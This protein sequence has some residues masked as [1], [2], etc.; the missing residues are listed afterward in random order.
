MCGSLGVFP[1]LRRQILNY[2]TTILQGKELEHFGLVLYHQHPTLNPEINL[3][4]IPG[5]AEND[6]GV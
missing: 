2:K 6:A 4:E 1:K 3:G 5:G